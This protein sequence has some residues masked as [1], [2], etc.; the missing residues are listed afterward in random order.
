MKN[1]IYL[2]SASPRRKE[3][4]KQLNVEF[5]QFSLDVDESHIKQE[6]PE[7]CVVR[8]ACLKAQTAVELG[9]KDRPVLGSDTIVVLDDKI[10]GKPKNDIHAKSMLKSLSGR[11]HQVMTAI[12]LASEKKVLSKLVITNV[13]FK[14]LSEQEIIDYIHTNEPKDKAGSYGIQGFAGRFVTHISGSYFSV[15]GLPLFETEQLLS[16][17]W[18]KS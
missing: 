12:A 17:F 5:E 6:S 4:L 14:T 1:K 3:L 2:A 15:V 13:T 7:E 18:N 11:S 8:L 16:H 10:L 9:Y